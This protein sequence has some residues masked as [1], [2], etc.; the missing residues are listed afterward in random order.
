MVDLGLV[1][2]RFTLEVCAQG[3]PVQTRPFAVCQGALLIAVNDSALASGVQP[4]HSRST[5]LAR[6]PDILFAERNLT[7]ES[8]ALRQIALW[9]LQFTPGVFLQPPRPLPDR[10]GLLLDIARSLMLFGG[11]PRL[12]AR[13]RSGLADTGFSA[14]IACAPTAAAAWL[15]ARHRDGLQA[16]D[17]AQ[18]RAMVA[19]LPLALLD[20]ASPHL[21]ALQAVGVRTLGDLMLL[22][23]AGLARRFGSGLLEDIDRALGQRADPRACFEAP[24]RFEAGL[25]L[26]SPVEQAEQLLFAA[27][28]LLV[29]LCG[30]L[31][32]RQSGAR[33]IE[34]LALHE[35]RPPTL[36]EIGLARPCREIEQLSLLVREALGRHKVLPAAVNT[37]RLR[38]HDVHAYAPASADLFPDASQAGEQIQRLVERLQARLGHEQVLQLHR[39]AEHRPEYAHREHPLNGLPA[40]PPGRTGQPPRHLPHPTGRPPRSIDTGSASPAWVSPIGPRPLWL[41]KAPLAL[42]ERNNRP[43]W[44]SPLVLLAG[45]ERIESGWWDDRLVQRDY[46]IAEDSS[47]RMLWIFRERQPQSGNGWFLHGHFG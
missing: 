8:E 33:R 30:W 26:P 22:P 14:Q 46:F 23:R 17:A 28:R 11:L 37:L 1:L 15:L 29:Q 44:E 21:S 18:T 20:A 32:A 40:P 3:L 42:S 10:A 43:F 16:A 19:R 12:L 13:V 35:R 38:C 31:T 5:A 4:G 9:A 41:L 36:I 39:V 6:S 27:R 34:I 25:E 47:H 2:P 24:D 7:Q 45:P